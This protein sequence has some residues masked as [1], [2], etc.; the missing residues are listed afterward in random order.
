MSTKNTRVKEG[1]KR[2]EKRKRKI[3]Q[4]NYNDL[5]GEIWKTV[6]SLNHMYEVSNLGRVRNTKSKKLL[7]LQTNASGYYIFSAY[8]EPNKPVT[9]PVHRAVAEVFLGKCPNNYE[10]NHIDG[11]KKNNNVNNL[12]YVTRSENLLHAYKIGLRKGPKANPRRGEDHPFAKLKEEDVILILKTHR[13]TGYGDR[14]LARILG[15]PKSAIGP[16]L[17]NRSWKHIDRNLI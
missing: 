17:R 7:K 11:N 1:K 15:F 10:V 2:N 8:I 4:Y 3:R 9:T 12:E 6:P 14:K 13:E 5:P 16:I